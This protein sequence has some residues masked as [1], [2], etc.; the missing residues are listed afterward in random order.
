[1]DLVKPSSGLMFWMLLFFG[2][3]FFILVKFV[4]PVI[5]KALKEREDSIQS[6]LDSAKQ[7][8]AEMAA[9]KADNEK[10]LAEARNERDR[11]LREARDTK[12][13]II[14]EAKNKAQSEAQ[15]LMTQARETINTEK[16]AAVAELKNQVAAMSIEIAEKILRTELSSDEKQK[17]LVGNLIKDINLN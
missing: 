15:K 4:W 2:I 9:L 8:K 16:N 10:L 7:V 5:L 13:S 3:I 1:M 6:A 14:A 17:A 12:D 11:L